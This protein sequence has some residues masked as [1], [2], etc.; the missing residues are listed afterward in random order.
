MV[1]PAVGFGPTPQMGDDGMTRTRS[2]ALL[3]EF[4]TPTVLFVH[5]RIP[6]PMTT[7]RSPRCA[8]R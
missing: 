1:V 4:R 5:F 6:M 8:S 2:I 3:S 7:H